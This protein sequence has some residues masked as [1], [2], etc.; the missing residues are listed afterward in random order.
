MIFDFDARCVF[1]AEYVDPVS[2][3]TVFGMKS[4]LTQNI[5][6]S[7]ALNEAKEV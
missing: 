4:I 5:A 3:T 7:E 2:A 1:T 6:D